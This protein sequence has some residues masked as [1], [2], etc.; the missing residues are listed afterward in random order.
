MVPIAIAR[1][2]AEARRRIRLQQ[3]TEFIQ[4]EASVL[5][6]FQEDLVAEPLALVEREY[7]LSAI[8]MDKEAMASLSST[9]LEPCTKERSQ[10]LPGGR[11]G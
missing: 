1:D 7:E 2:L 6:Q 10:D 9:L 4:R 5:E 8:L 11:L 3:T